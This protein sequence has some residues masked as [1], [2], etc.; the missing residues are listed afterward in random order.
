[1]KYAI[2]AL[3]IVVVASLGTMGVAYYN[4]PTIFDSSEPTSGCCHQTVKATPDGCCPLS[5][6]AACVADSTCEHS[7]PVQAAAAAADA[8]LKSGE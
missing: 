5:G 6:G 7:C 8:A 3:L 2:G 4:D 1:M